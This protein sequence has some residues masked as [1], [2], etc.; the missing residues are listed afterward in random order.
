MNTIEVRVRHIDDAD[1]HI[2]GGFEPAKLYDLRRYI[3][4]TGFGWFDGIH[5]NVTYCDEQL[6]ASNGR[7]FYEIIVQ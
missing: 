2:I 3:E 1:G 4:D 7:V 5:E 6:V